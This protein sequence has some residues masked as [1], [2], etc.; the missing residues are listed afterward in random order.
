MMPQLETNDTSSW[1]GFK[2]E[3]TLG[4]ARLA[5]PGISTQKKEKN[6]E[7]LHMLAP[8]GSWWPYALDTG[9][10]RLIPENQQKKTEPSRLS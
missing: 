4:W 7:G 2:V 1:Q 5:G 6:S 8:S 3:D 9:G 10:N